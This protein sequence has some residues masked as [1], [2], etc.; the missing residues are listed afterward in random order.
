[1]LYLFSLIICIV[2]GV[3]SWNAIE[4]ENFPQAIVFLLLWGFLT[5]I[6]YWILEIVYRNVFDTEK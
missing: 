3:L 5:T 4:P 1:M 2:S 6:G